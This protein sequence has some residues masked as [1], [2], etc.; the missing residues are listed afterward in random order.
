M[1]GIWSLD[2]NAAT[3]VQMIH[4]AKC[5]N[6][7]LNPGLIGAG[8]MF[9]RHGIKTFCWRYPCVRAKSCQLYSTLCDPMDC[10]PP[11]SSVHGILQG[12]TQMGC[13]ALLQGDCPDPETEP[14]SFTSPALA[15][16][17]FTTS[18]TWEATAEGLTRW[19]SNFSPGQ[20]QVSG[21]QINTSSD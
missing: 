2:G 10:S 8:S 20:G 13:H 7:T 16:G 12:R 5:S 4:Q 9:L 15:G 11:G 6:E 17:F 14:K 18:T 19:L 21:H 3:A 1:Q